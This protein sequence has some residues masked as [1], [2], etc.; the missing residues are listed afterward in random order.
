MANDFC[1]QCFWYDGDEFKGK[2][3]EDKIQRHIG[4]VDGQHEHIINGWPEAGSGEKACKRFKQ[5]I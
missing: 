1:G 4:S 3:K 2:C 5:I